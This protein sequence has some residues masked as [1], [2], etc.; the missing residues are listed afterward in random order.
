MFVKQ[1]VPKDDNS[2]VYEV[3]NRLNTGG[4]NLEPQEIRISLYHSEFYQ[5]LF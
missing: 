5:M 1:N 2:S 4:V 3:F